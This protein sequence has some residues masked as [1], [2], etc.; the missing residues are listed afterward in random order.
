MTIQPS[1][2]KRKQ[3]TRPIREYPAKLR[4][5]LALTELRDGS[6][7]LST[8]IVAPFPLWHSSLHTYTHYPALHNCMLKQ[9]DLKQF[10]YHAI[11]SLACP[12]SLVNGDS[13]LHL[14]QSTNT[15]FTLCLRHITIQYNVECI[16]VNYK[17][18]RVSFKIEQMK[19]K[20]TNSFSLQY[21]TTCSK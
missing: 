7:K 15:M 20:L 1:N 16:S 18:I 12:S 17:M 5:D 6:Y 10:N 2:R 4:P 14:Q 9:M 19:K 11:H 3:Q 13:L 21:C 8:I